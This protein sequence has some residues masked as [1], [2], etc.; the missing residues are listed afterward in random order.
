[1]R[2]VIGRTKW[3]S[4]FGEV[5]FHHRDGLPT[6]DGRIQDGQ[7]SE[8]K[9]TNQGEEEEEESGARRKDKKPK[10]PHDALFA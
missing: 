7:N 1:V 9:G 2:L 8:T 6:A 5:W 10:A 3:A 4:C